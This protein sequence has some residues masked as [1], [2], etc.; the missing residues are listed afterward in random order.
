M[1]NRLKWAVV[2]GAMVLVAGVWWWQGGAKEGGDAVSGGASAASQA[3][4]WSVPE[5]RAEG[6]SS[7]VIGVAQLTP[8]QVRQRLLVRGSLQ[9]TEPSGD[10]CVRDGQT[11]APCKGLRDRFEYYILG[12]GEVSIADIRGLVEDEARRAVGERLAQSIM[13]IFDKYWR[14]RTYDWKSSFIQSDRSTWMPVFEEQRSV[15]RQIL[16]QPW[17]DAFFQDDEKHFQEY[18]AQLESGQ[19]PPP[20]PGEPVP[21]MDP[22]K[23]PAAVR[24]ERVARY[25]EDAAKRLDEVDAQWAEWDRRL[26]AARQEWERIQ[27]QA[28]LSDPQKHDE[29]ARYVDAHFQ[30]KERIRVRALLKLR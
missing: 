11:L 25:G 13:D 26:V 5:G 29:M 17:A 10:W 8:E 12:I 28:H 24:A 27:A 1:Q 19:P 16:G 6:G 3:G 15:R 20:H 4:P 14:I 21:Q 9:G 22:G 7:S 2:A 23:D 30:D 18:Y